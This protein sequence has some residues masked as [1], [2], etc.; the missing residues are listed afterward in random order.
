MV[1]MNCIDYK[2]LNVYIGFGAA[3]VS[4]SKSYSIL[5]SFK[6]VRKLFNY[7]VTLVNIRE[8][9]F[10]YLGKPRRARI[11]RQKQSPKSG[12]RT[13]EEGEQGPQEEGRCRG[14]RRRGDRCHRSH[15]SARGSGF[16]AVAS[17]TAVV[18]AA[19]RQRQLLA[20]FGLSGEQVRHINV[21]LKGL[22]LS[23]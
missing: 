21:M 18:A 6:N 16:I 5:Q 11:P 4:C 19:Q 20:D 17:L 9:R 14:G 22:I 15:E 10:M 12:H 13:P 7:F 8:L 23:C 1:N 3:R 2:L